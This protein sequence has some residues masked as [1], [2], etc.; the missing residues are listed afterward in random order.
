M[1]Y[2]I[3]MNTKILKFVGYHMGYSL[4]P[5]FADAL[6]EITVDK[7]KS[8]HWIW[9]I[10]P[11]DKPSS[12]HGSDFVLSDASEVEA[13]LRNDYLRMNYIHMLCAIGCRLREIPVSEYDEF[14]SSVDLKKIYASAVLFG[15]NADAF[16]DVRKVCKHMEGVLGPYLTMGDRMKELRDRLNRQ[17]LNE[18]VISH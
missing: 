12:T 10:I 6:Y 18:S 3:M 16:E 5:S 1:K 8:G 15:R 9:Y 17:F 13:F 4:S 7:R 11:Y 2:Y 14:L